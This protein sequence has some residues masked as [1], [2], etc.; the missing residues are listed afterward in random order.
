MNNKE[1]LIR[2]QRISEAMVNGYVGQQG[3]FGFILKWLGYPII[4]QSDSESGSD[5]FNLDVYES[6][7][8]NKLSELSESTEAREIGWY[9]DGLRYGSNI[10]MKYDNFIK[11]IKVTHNGKIVYKEEGGELLTYV[12]SPIWENQIESLCYIA[13]KVETRRKSFINEELKRQ[14]KE[15]K[16]SIYKDLNEKWGI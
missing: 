12:P 15:K 1:E 7:D 11:E 13:K 8:E 6:V 16:H 9:F 10:D 14:I 5:L 4:E 2:E 3:K